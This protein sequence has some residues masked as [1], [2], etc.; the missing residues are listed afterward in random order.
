[1][2]LPQHSNFGQSFP[3]FVLAVTGLSV[4]MTWL[5]TRV[6]GS[7]AL[8]ML[9]HAANNHTNRIVLTRVAAPGDSMNLDT[10][11]IAMLVLTILWASAAVFLRTMQGRPSGR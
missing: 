7:L 5:Y 9:M 2:A 3:A 10:S 11:L 6:N 1:M 8:M 4:A